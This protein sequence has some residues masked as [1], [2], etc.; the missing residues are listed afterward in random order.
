M[1][2]VFI[3]ALLFSVN[4][5]A[6]NG[7]LTQENLLGLERIE[8]PKVANAAWNYVL[9]CSGIKPEYSWQNP[10]SIRWYKVKFPPATK[11]IGYTMY[12]PPRI[13][14]DSEYTDSPVTIAHE[15]MHILYQGNPRNRCN[16]VKECHPSDP[17]LRCKLMADQYVFVEVYKKA[18]PWE[19]K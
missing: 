1:R 7:K 3:L 13:F 4:T 16:V 5:C 2:F 15:L 11:Y 8:K 17:F 10:D 9:R 12:D 19:D 6:Y 18:V 14:L